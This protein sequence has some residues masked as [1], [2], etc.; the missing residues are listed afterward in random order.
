MKAWI[1]ETHGNTDGLALVNWPEPEVGSNE[2]LVAIK[3]VS[4]NYRD[5]GTLRHARPGNI[6]PPLIPCSDG[7]GEVVAVGPN[8]SQFQPGD[9]VVGS[10]FHDWTSGRFNVDYH[11]ACGGG[12]KQ[13]LLCERV[14][15]PQHSLLPV[16]DE[17]STAEAATWPVAGVTAWA[18]LFTR[19]DLQLGATVLTLGTGGVSIFALQ[20]A[21]AAGAKVIITSS[22]DEK[23]ERARKLGA[24]HTINYKTHPDWDQEVLRLTDGKGVDHIIEVGGSGTLE[25]SMACV[26]AGGQIGLIGVLTG[27]GPPTSSLFPLMQRNVRLDGIYAGSRDDLAALIEFS[28]RHNL[29]P[30]IDETFPFDQARVAFDTLAAAGHFGKVVIQIA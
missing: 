21:V 25:K 24:A 23:L 13:G 8:V 12:S 18:S 30:V 17:F 11:R 9:R 3:A 14:A 4:L 2:V 6:E 15:L 19:G 28:Q 29:H 22:S 20:L 1:I 16:P 7:A 27:F 5:L 10:F 26:A